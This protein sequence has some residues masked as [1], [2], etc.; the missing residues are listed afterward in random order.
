VD[1]EGMDYTPFWDTLC[2][3]KVCICDVSNVLWTELEVGAIFSFTLFTDYWG[4]WALSEWLRS[5]TEMVAFLRPVGDH[6]IVCALLSE[7]KAA[8]AFDFAHEVEH[9]RHSPTIFFS[10]CFEQV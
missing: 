6:D 4:N 3:Q 2:G 9:V 8:L 5:F 7:M 1:A 10:D